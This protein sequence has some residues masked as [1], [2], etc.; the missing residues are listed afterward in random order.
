MGEGLYRHGFCMIVV[1]IGAPPRPRSVERG[2]GGEGMPRVANPMK[3]Y[4]YGLL[5]Q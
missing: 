5:E 2:L 1:N 4:S 3:H